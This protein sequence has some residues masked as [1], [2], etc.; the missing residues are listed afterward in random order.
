M[1][2]GAIEGIYALAEDGRTT[3]ALAALD[4]MLAE[5]NDAPPLHALRAFLLLD[6]RRVADAQRAADLAYALDEEDPYVLHAVG[7]VAIAAGEPRRALEAAQALLAIDEGDHDAV[8]L[9]ARARALIGQWDEV[10]ARAEWVLGEDPQNAE[11]AFLRIA[12][13]ESGKKKGARLD[14]K[15]W[16][17][18][19]A[20]FPHVSIARAGR[21][22]TLLHRGRA[23]HAETEFRDALALDPNDPWAKEGLVL[24][25]KARYPG[26]TLLLRFFFWLQSLPPGTQT[27]VLIGGVVGSRLLRTVAVQNPSLKPLIYPV[28]G[29]YFLFV[30]LTWLA[31]PLLNLVLLTKPEGRRL[32]DADDRRGALAVG[33]ALAAAAVLALLSVA[34]PWKAALLGALVVAFASLPIAAAYNCRPSPQRTRL[35]IVSLLVILSGLMATVAPAGV[36]GILLFGGII[37]VVITTWVS[38]GMIRRSHQRD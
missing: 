31:D 12:A 22:W 21:A 6:L 5:V 36:S 9:D 20:R 29:A 18:L 3:E 34:T 23:G 25:L 24:A 38:R 30:M 7:R 10:I 14:P 17:E 37:T 33:G 2:G 32:L 4:E 35:Q 11:A 27:A 19:A 15:E 1:E 16:D 26:Y 13:L 8:L 28:I